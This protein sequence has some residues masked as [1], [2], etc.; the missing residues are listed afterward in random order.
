MLTFGGVDPQISL[1]HLLVVR[2][3]FL[4]F[5]WLSC[6]GKWRAAREAD[7][8]RPPAP[9][10][11]RA[12]EIR[13]RYAIHKQS[14]FCLC[15]FVNRPAPAASLCCS[16]VFSMHSGAWLTCSDRLL[17]I[18]VDLDGIVLDDLIDMDDVGSASLEV[19]PF[20]ICRRL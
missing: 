16:L 3:L 10:Q 17:V 14:A 13:R 4:S 1:D 15:F 2:S 7:L 9:A 5:F 20:A 19:G 18:A 8:R 6:G 11:I 12:V